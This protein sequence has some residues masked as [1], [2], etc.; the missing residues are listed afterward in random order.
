M[1][2]INF[3]AVAVGQCLLV[4]SEDN[5][6][7]WRVLNH[8]AQDIA[9]LV[10]NIERTEQNVVLRTV[11]VA[12]LSNVPSLLSTYT[13]QIFDTLNQALDI[14]HRSL[15]GKLT[16]SIPLDREKDENTVGIE[17]AGEEQMEQETEEEA[18]IRRRKQDL[19]TE[20]DMEIKHVAWILEAQRIAAETITNICS[21]DDNGKISTFPIK[22]ANYPN[23]IM[24][25]VT[26]NV[27]FRWQCFGR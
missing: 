15:L 12:I 19:P 26:K 11:A 20:H 27:F 13:N 1:I 22:K 3:S 18:T 10:T 5:P 4:I 25:N 21:S 24:E 14:N 8:F 23:C 9:S 17:V 6:V 2:V 7:A 16:S